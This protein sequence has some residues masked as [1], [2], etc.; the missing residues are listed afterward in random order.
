MKFI[1]VIDSR[2]VIVEL[3]GF[4]TYSK[5]GAQTGREVRDYRRLVK[6]LII[7]SKEETNI[8]D[9][10]AAED[11]EIIQ[12]VYPSS[13][14]RL[15]VYRA[16]GFSRRKHSTLRQKISTHGHSQMLFHNQHRRGGLK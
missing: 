6:I 9:V 1:Q 7:R 10:Q 4:V 3:N 15:I 13:I 2:V 12:P 14:A 8:Q 16:H 5:Q 11:D